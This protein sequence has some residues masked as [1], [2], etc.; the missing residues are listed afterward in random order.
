MSAVITLNVGENGSQTDRQT[1]LS[2]L[3]RVACSACSGKKVAAC[4]TLHCRLTDVAPVALR[5]NYGAHIIF[6]IMH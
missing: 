4:D 2:W 1:A 5:V 3:D 6:I